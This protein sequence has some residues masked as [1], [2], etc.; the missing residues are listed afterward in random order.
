MLGEQEKEPRLICIKKW[1]DIFLELGRSWGMRVR[2]GWRGK[3]ERSF[4][5]GL[6]P[7]LVS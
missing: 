1:E 3:E 4:S 2:R 5:M 7:V 6:T